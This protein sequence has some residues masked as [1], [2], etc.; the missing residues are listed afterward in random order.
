MSHAIYVK[1]LFF[2]AIFN[3]VLK[4]N[5]FIELA[6]IAKIVK[7]LTWLAERLLLQ[8]LIVNY[9]LLWLK[10]QSAI[11]SH[12]FLKFDFFLQG[13]ISSL[14]L[15]VSCLIDNC[16]KLFEDASYSTVLQKRYL[17][18]RG[19]TKSWKKEK[20]PFRS[21]WTSAVAHLQNTPI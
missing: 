19:G 6:Q 5:Y 16:P 12:T 17:G 15:L 7:W 8:I 9:L 14:V 1:L 3:F 13:F 10:G 11:F 4:V 21:K 18:T 2:W 20:S